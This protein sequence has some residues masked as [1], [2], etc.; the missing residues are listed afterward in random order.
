MDDHDWVTSQNKE[1][2]VSCTLVLRHVYVFGTYKVPKYN[3]VCETAARVYADIE[4]HQRIFYFVNSLT[5]IGAYMRQLFWWALFK[6]DNFLHFV[7]WQRL[8]ARNVRKLFRKKPETVFTGEK[9]G[10]WN[11]WPHI[12]VQDYFQPAGKGGMWASPLAQMLKR[13]PRHEKMCHVVPVCVGLCLL[14]CAVLCPFVL[15]CVAYT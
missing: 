6:V 2:V 1:G 11:Q 4:T 7:R 15:F 9:G 13:V 3:C 14:F 10:F 8:I 5:A 12:F